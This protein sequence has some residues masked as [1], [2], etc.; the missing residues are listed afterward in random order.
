MRSRV[1]LAAGLVAVATVSAA[2][3]VGPDTGPSAVTGDNGG[4]A[5]ATSSAAPQ[6]PALEA[7]RNDLSWT[8]CAKALTTRFGVPAPAA[9]VTLQCATFRSPIDPDESSSGSEAVL[10]D[11]VRLRSASTP[12]NAAPLV[13]TTGSDMPASRAL[14][15]LA[16]G[17]GKSVLDT[18]PI[19]GVE[20]RGTSG[21]STVDCMTTLDTST[22]VNN[23][24]AGYPGPLRAP[25][26]PASQQQR[27]DR[28]AKSASVASD[29]CSDTLNPNQ[30]SFSSQLAATDLNTLRTKWGVSRLGI[31]GL[32]RGADVAIA[33]A[34]QYP[35]H[36]G[37]LILDT[38]TNFSANTR[39][40]ASTLATGVQ[41]AL[42]T[43][44]RRCQ[45]TTR[46]PLGTDPTAMISS[47]MNKAA[48]GQ[49]GD[50]S[51]ANVLTA[52]TT[53]VATAVSDADRA[54]V[55]TAIAA[56]D[57]GDAKPLG[58]L[59]EAST[60]LRDTQPQLLSRCNDSSGSV[61]LDQIPGLIT[62]WS[63]QNP[64][65][66]A[67]T[68]LSLVRCNGWA[69]SQPIKSPASYPVAPLVLSGTNDPINGSD[70]TG[71]DPGFTAARTDA[72]KLSWDG[73]GYSVLA[74]S[75][76]A[77]ATVSDYLKAAPMTGPSERACP[78]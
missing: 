38:P 22:L 50:Y 44:G 69:T 14:L 34:S 26:N 52:I 3:A 46:C 2:C 7:P 47:V 6:I 23:G 21:R 11:A 49:L 73:L 13:L 27:I 9:G 5:A 32:G 57:R 28:L 41:R 63:K 60:Q 58:R 16:A 65:T 36:L 68:A 37:R 51:D 24:I 4:P 62:E 78:A 1:F 20:L 31:L 30:L 25:A 75:G 18:H 61:G 70:A 54:S 55:A 56:A 43:F 45:A 33:Y 76:C 8:D 10:I 40:R 15:M 42:V 77:A 64:L 66:G 67:S 53:T 39:D 19:V 71:L 12:Q 48:H 74:H 17:D 72:V 29:T 35:D 59:I